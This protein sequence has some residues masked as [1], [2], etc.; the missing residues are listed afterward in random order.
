M[1][2]QQCSGRQC[3]VLFGQA[4]VEVLEMKGPVP[5]NRIMKLNI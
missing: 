2:V 5:D 1:D 4:L 3:P